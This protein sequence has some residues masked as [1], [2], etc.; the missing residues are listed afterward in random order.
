MIRYSSVLATLLVLL[1]INTCSAQVID[2]ASIVKS[3]N[4]CWHAFSHEYS[5]IYGLEEEEINRYS[6]QRVC[7]TRDS[8]SLYLGVV[9]APTYA[10]RKVNSEEYAKSNFDCTK[11]RLGIAIDS[12]YEVTISSNS[13]PSKNGTVHKMTD[14]IVIGEECIY[15]TV[16][17]VIF[18]LFDVN[19]NVRPRSSH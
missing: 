10:I 15:I 4:K 18:K 11:Q 17:G 16:D 8:I 7:F 1:C 6:K 2:S 19:S 12:V 9:Y 5:T 13:K 3:L 14:V